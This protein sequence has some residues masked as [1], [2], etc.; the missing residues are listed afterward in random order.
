MENEKKK[1]RSRIR[2]KVHGSTVELSKEDLMSKRIDSE[3]TD[4]VADPVVTSV[5]GLVVLIVL[6]LFIVGIVRI[7][8]AAAR[9]IE[10]IVMNL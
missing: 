3:Q 10:R 2:R 8:P 7:A 1:R 6:L 9:F 5:T 4:P